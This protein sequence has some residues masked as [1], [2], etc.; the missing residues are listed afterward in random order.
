[1]S[2]EQPPRVAMVSMHTSPLDMPGSGDAGG[3]NVHLAETARRIAATGTAVD[4][5][6]RVGGQAGD[7]FGRLGDGVRVLPVGDENMRSLTKEQLP[8]QATDFA[9]AMIARAASD[10]QCSYDLVHSHYWISGLAGLRA[11]DEW[12]VP[13]VHTMHTLGHVKNRQLAPGDHLEPQ[14]RLDNERQLV[15]AADTLLANTEYER[16]DLIEL[17]DADPNRI[18]V[19][20]PG[21]DL[22]LFRPGDKAKA[23]YRTGLSPH[24]RVLLFVGRLQPL[25]APDVL[26][27]AVHLMVE[28]Q[29]QLREELQLVLC[30]GASGAAADYPSDLRRLAAQ[31]GVNDVVDFR[32]PLPANQLAELYRAADLVAVP[33][34]SES[35]GLVA[36]EAQASG[37]PVVAAAVG[38]L[39]TSV[40]DGRGGVLI[41]SHEPRIWAETL[42]TSLGQ[43]RLLAEFADSGPRHAAAF[44]WQFTAAATMSAYRGARH[45]VPELQAAH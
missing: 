6:T 45:R 15:A 13:L 24:R 42:A 34:H 2:I 14:S 3:L 33:S 5:F 25:K 27:R 36:L 23:R 43:P 35:F 21:V 38:G 26:I 4:I 11:A 12:S 16:R 8:A 10:P 22:E 9:N 31:L 39:T 32:G 1:M 41:P 18:R 20:P 29:P 30:G 19:V 40:A 44:D 37:T 7:R 28:K 17:Y